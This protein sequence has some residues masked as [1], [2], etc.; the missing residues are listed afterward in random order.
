MKKTII[1]L[2][3]F[4]ALTLSIVGCTSS[5]TSNTEGID[6]DLTQIGDVMV[7][8]I[9]VEMLTQPESYLGQT[10]RVSGFYEPFFSPRTELEHHF[11]RIVGSATCCPQFLEIRWT[12]DNIPGNLPN[13]GVE[14]EVIGVFGL[15]DI[16]EANLL[17]IPYLAV[18]EVLII[19]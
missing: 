4:L 7:Y 1:S 11:V 2:F 12:D 13:E 8:G 6:L 14:I 5:E 16:E 15:Y 9:V 19:G 18:N 17:G 3:L 10:V